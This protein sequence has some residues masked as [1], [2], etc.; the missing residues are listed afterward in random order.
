MKILLVI[1]ILILISIAVFVLLKKKPI[2]KNSGPSC[3]K[4][5]TLEQI[6][7]IPACKCQPGT[8]IKRHYDGKSYCAIKNSW[9][10]SSGWQACTEN[11]PTE[12]SSC[13]GPCIINP[14]I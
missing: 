1:I 2:F 8:E 13:K 12:Y 10:C 4:C 9:N 14:W 3:P 7:L 11:C 6:G 5:A